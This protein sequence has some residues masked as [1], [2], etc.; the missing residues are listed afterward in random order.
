MNIEGFEGTQKNKTR[1]LFIILF[2]IIIIITY[3]RYYSW[4]NFR[5]LS[6]FR[7]TSNTPR[8]NIFTT[9][10]IKCHFGF[11]LMATKATKQPKRNEGYLISVSRDQ[12]KENF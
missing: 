7:E 1:I 6:M 12:N 9:F 2:I 3:M 10:L 4:Y 5:M 11:I 8:F